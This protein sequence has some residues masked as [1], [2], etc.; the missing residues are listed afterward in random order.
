M[1]EEQLFLAI[2]KQTKT[3]LPCVVKYKLKNLLYQVGEMYDL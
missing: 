1:T 2:S 3:Y